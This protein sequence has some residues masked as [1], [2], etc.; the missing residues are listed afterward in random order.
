MKRILIVVGTRPNFIKVTQFRK[1]AE[2]FPELNIKIAHTG[3]HFD[4]NMAE[5]FFSQFKL[6]PD[7]FLD[8]EPSTPVHQMGEIM[9]KLEDLIENTF[10]P[11]LIITPGDVNST[12]AV[13]IVANKKGIKLAHLESG[14]R[15]RDRNMPEEINRILTDEIS[16][17][18]F[19][20]EKSG[21][22]NLEDEYK[23]G[24]VFMVG[25]TMIDTL[26]AF[27]EEIDKADIIREQ[28]IVNDFVLMTIHRPSN[29]DSK[30]GLEKL[31]DLLE[32][33]SQSLQIVFPIHPRT[34]NNIDKFKLTQKFSAIPNVI[35]TEALGY[36]EFQ[37][38]IK[39][40]KFVV[41]DSGGIQEETTF[42]QVPCLTLRDSTERPITTD[43]GSN[44]LTTF[45]VDKIMK[46]VRKIKKG[47]YKKGEIPPLW[48]GK[49]TRRILE[50]IN[51]LNL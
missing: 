30:E 23:P 37:H 10:F 40:C 31:I 38:L 46:M 41:T 11:D 5:V 42:R 32:R 45:D 24:K 27:E 43:I 44:T 47:T 22:T 12:L 16:D 3:Q 1:V 50:H 8:I 51:D 15:S 20:T 49:A 39:K 48:D 21:K 19:V 4:K 33:L 7:Y 28:G 34:K 25:N 36:F 6:E 35:L 18:Y 17:Y 2:D 13:A 26:V 9:I 14:L 29:V